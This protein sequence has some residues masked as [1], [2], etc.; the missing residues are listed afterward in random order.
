[1]QKVPEVS[2]IPCTN[3][4]VDRSQRKTC[5]LE[6]ETDSDMEGGSGRAQPVITGPLDSEEL[7]VPIVQLQ[8]GS[9]VF[10]IRIPQFSIR[11][12]HLHP[13]LAASLHDYK[14]SKAQQRS[15][16]KQCLDDSNTEAKNNKGTKTIQ[17]R[18][19]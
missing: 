12:C 3:K 1:M 11:L 18:T 2:S 14:V 19:A 15:Y 8:K 10:P 6:R 5:K 9:W 17:G 16:K 4:W 13:A 7:T